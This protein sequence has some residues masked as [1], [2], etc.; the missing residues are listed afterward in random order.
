VEAEV[1][2]SDA[3]F[4]RLA[5]A[6]RF[7]FGQIP[8]GYGWVFPKRA[9]LSIGVCTMRTGVNL[10]AG[11]TRYLDALG[12]SRPEHVDKHGF[13]IPLGPRPEGLVR[14]RVLLAGDA[15][16]LADPVTGEGISAAIESGT[17]A[18]RAILAGSDDPAAVAGRYD[19]ALAAIRREVRIGRVLA[20]LTYDLPRLRRWAF[21]LHGQALTEAMTSVLMGDRTYASLFGRARTYAY[22]FGLRRF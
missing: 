18:G 3:D 11:L 19:R 15:A 16:A 14:G 4:A 8:A 17:S 13:F 20:R 7:D 22:L 9:H 12:L 10:N 5:G 6:A 21:R 1:R 2:V